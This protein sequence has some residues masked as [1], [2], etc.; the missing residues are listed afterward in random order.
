[1]SFRFVSSLSLRKFL[2]HWGIFF[3]DHARLRSGGKSHHRE[4]VICSIISQFS[5]GL[6]AHSPKKFILDF[7]EKVKGYQCVRVIVY[8]RLVNIPHLLIENFFL[9]TDGTNAFKKLT[10]VIHGTAALESFIVECKTLDNVIPQSLSCSLSELCTLNGLHTIANG[11]Y[12]IQA[13]ILD[14]FIRICN[15]Q[16][17]QIG[18]FGKLPPPEKY[19]LYVW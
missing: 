10:K 15:L 12:H 17:M 11:Y 9:N 19:C 3:S 14:R 4:S 8:T 5:C 13:I 18:I 1:M 6:S 16:K 2:P 7:A